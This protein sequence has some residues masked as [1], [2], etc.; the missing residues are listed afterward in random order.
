MLDAARRLVFAGTLL[1]GLLA[2]S[3]LPAPADVLLIQ[4]STT[5][6]SRLLVPF[7]A[8]IEATAQHKLV[9]VPNKSSV[10]LI[11]LLEG[12]ADLA[13]ISTSIESELALLQKTNPMLPFAKLRSF[14][15]SQTRAAFA[16]HASNPV[17]ATD[18]AT[19]RRIL[20]GEI[21]NWQKLGGRDLPLQI[22]I[23]REGGGV[24]LSVEAELL[25]GKRIS[26]PNL[27][28]VGIGEQ[29]VETV[30]REPGA[31]GLAQF[32]ILQKSGLPELATDH[33][34]QQQLSLVSLDGPSPA[35]QAVIDAARAIASAL[36]K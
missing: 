14:Q 28:T 2:A 20:L 34:V 25:G 13:M 3:A 23:V 31:L 17:R 10:G 18:A 6:N 12:R 33:I 9:V 35:K 19:M 26:A 8:D 1:V 5:F 4:G 30:G 36:L 7:Q 22:L 11:A 32:G 15:I 29:V 21:V 16:V 27:V 24:Q